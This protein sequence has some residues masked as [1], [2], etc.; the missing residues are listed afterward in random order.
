MSWADTA[1]NFWIFGGQTGTNSFLPINDLWKFSGGQY[2]KPAW[3]VR[4]FGRPCRKQYPRSPSTRDD[5]DGC[6]GEFVAVWRWP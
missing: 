2:S 5:M 4:H 1:G 6:V 3:G